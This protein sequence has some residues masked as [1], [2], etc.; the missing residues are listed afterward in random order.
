MTLGKDGSILIF[1][2]GWSWISALQNHLM[3][4][5]VFGTSSFL[6]LPLHSSIARNEQH[7]I[8]EPVPK[9]VRKIVLSTN[10]AESSVTI[11]DV[12]YVIDLCKA[13]IKLFSS[14]NNLV[15]YAT[16]WASKSNLLQRRG[17]AGRTRPGICFHLCSK[18]RFSRM[19]EHIVPEIMRSPLT[20]LVLFI[21]LLGLGSACSFLNKALE[22]PSPNAIIEAESML[23]DMKALDSSNEL[24]PLGRLMARLPIDAHLSKMVVLGGIFYCGDAMALITAACSTP[25]PWE[26]NGRGCLPHY[27]KHL[28]GP[29]HSD[30]L[31]I[32]IAYM[33][34]ATAKHMLGEDNERG[35]VQYCKTKE[36]N[37]NCMKM[38]D[39]IK[40]QLIESMVAAGFPRLCFAPSSSEEIFDMVF[41]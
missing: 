20:D 11:E 28:S 8:F 5:G 39:N 24:T 3:K 14:H 27:A 34:F 13:K 12:V 37:Y 6:I 32:L 22:S 25:E 10:I 15:Q 31:A 17:R 38:L 30:H 23:R 2:P 21:K 29:R 35:L 41:L 36:L 19:D 40:N 1:L 16:V 33:D 26:C 4:H 7:R 9:G 18:A